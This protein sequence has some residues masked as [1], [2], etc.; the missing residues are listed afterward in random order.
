MLFDPV[1]V[2]DRFHGRVEKLVTG[3]LHKRL[4]TVILQIFRTFFRKMSGTLRPEAHRICPK[5]PKHPM[6]SRPKGEIY[7][8]FRDRAK[9]DM[10]TA[11]L[12]DLH[13]IKKVYDVD[14]LIALHLHR[15]FLFFRIKNGHLDRH[16]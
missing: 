1:R 9:F 3:L 13:F 10:K 12:I 6:L 4:H 16:S 7:A 15:H 5:F 14:P 2:N 11:H 8:L